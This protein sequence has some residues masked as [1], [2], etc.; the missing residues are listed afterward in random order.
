MSNIYLIDDA[1]KV[2]VPLSKEINYFLKEKKIIVS[3]ISDERTFGGAFIKIGVKKKH[4]LYVSSSLTEKEL[5]EIVADKYNEDI[6][7]LYRCY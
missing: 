3:V 5:K 6:D 4:V 2:S 1:S 7:S